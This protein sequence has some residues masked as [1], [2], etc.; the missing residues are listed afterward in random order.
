MKIIGLCG[1][2]GSGKGKVCEVFRENN[3]PTID[4]D[5]LYR[6]M[7]SQKSPCL[8]ALKAEFGK[9]IITDN[10]DLNRDKLAEIV[11]SGKDMDIKR[12]KLNEISHRFILD[13]TRCRIKQFEKDGF[14]LVVVDAPLLFES[15]FDSEC[16][17][18]VCVI[19]DRNVR[20]QR[21][22]S[23]DNITLE[24]AKRRIAAQLS[25]GETVSRSDFV[26]RNN[27]DIEELRGEVKSVITKILKLN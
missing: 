17:F 21:I 14:S 16:D 1:G 18:V 23:R 5:A 13:E 4:T 25:D 26:I 27:S 3:I 9:E 12:A 24:Q 20:I 19:A 7:T 11:F 8:D 2:S 15:G 6:E 22:M 10:G